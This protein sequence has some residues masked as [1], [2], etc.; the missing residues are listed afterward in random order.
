MDALL[1]DL[2]HALAVMRRERGFTAA[3]L[4]ALALGIGATTAVFSVL[5]GVL[6]RPLPYPEPDRLVRIYE[7]HPGAPKPPG[8][9]ETSNTTLNAWTPHLRTLEDIA[10]YY[11]L[12]YTVAFPDGPVRLHGGQVAPSLFPLLRATPQ[13]GRF[14]HAGEDAPR[15]NLYVVLSDRL[16]RE[17]LGAAPDAVGRTLTIEGKPHVIVGVAQPGFHFPDNDAQLWT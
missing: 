14:F 1:K 3:A 5:Y 11:A 4:L 7:E 15:A 12:E 17:R 6:L 16:W 10:P 8:E 2:K 13:L 9:P